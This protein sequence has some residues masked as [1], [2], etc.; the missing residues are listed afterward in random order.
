[1]GGGSQE[2]SADTLSTLRR[3]KRKLEK[4]GRA[5]SKAVV[6]NADRFAVAKQVQLDAAADRISD[7]RRILRRK[8]RIPL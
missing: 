6:L 1:L 8:E 7:T 5:R 2:G 3:V 4:A